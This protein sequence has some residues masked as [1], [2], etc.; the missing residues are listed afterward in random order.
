MGCKEAIPKINLW[1]TTLILF[2][3]CEEAEKEQDSLIF[4][5]LKL[6]MLHQ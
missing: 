2:Q 5:H 1:F 6:K 4:N 3:L